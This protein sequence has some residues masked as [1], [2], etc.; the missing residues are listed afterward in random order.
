MKQTGKRSAALLLA[1]LAFLVLPLRALSL[2]PAAQPLKD[3][4]IY[5]KLFAD[6]TVKSAYVVNSFTLEQAGSFTDYGNYDEIINLTTADGLAARGDAIR[7]NAQKGKFFYQGN[8]QSV[9]LPWTVGISYL[10]NGKPVSAKEV[11]GA[12][13]M[14]EIVLR[15]DENPNADPVF[16]KNYSLQVAM[17]LDSVRCGNIAA[18]DATIAAAGKNK[19]LNFIKLPD[20][21]AEYS[22]TMKAADFEMG[23]IQISAVPLSLS[24]DRP[25]TGG[26]TQDLVK[27]QDAIRDLNDGTRSLANGGGDME[28]GLYQFTDGLLEMW[29]G[30]NELEDGFSELV[31]GN[32]E[33]KGGSS[34]ILGA[35]NTIKS[36][37]SAF[38]SVDISGLTELAAASAA[39]RGGL[40]GLSGGLNGLQGGLSHAGDLLSGNQALIDS[41]NGQIAALEGAEGSEQLI[42]LLTAARDQLGANSGMIAGV[43]AGISGESGLAAGAGALLVQYALFDAGIQALPA[44]LQEMTGG[45]LSLKDGIDKLASNYGDFHSGLKEYLSGVSQLYR[46]YQKLVDGFDGLRSGSTDLASGMSDLHK[47]MLELADGTDDMRDETADMDAQMQD[48]IDEMLEKYTFEEFEPVSFISQKNANVELVQFVLMTEEI[49]A[50]EPDE[51]PEVREKEPTFWQ[52]LLALFGL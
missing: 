7:I 22:V 47:G 36:G 8:L 4:V 50:P 39:I 3:E 40:E 30:M 24:F 28:E 38:D 25:E 32:P 42:G 52:R 11:A 1:A 16:T 27:L 29:D 37:L 6:G 19:V 9:E 15:I 48:K 49:K 23:G 21:N 14:L 51:P 20:S 33:L 26:M 17:T 43:N 35:L 13:G 31:E 46:G 5:A 44:Q 41:I 45:M 10:L 2:Q 18:K 12:S 34:Q